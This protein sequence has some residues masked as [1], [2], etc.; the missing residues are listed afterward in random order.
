MVRFSHIENSW[1]AWVGF[2]WANIGSAYAS[3]L[4]KRGY[5]IEETESVES[6]SVP[7]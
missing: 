3:S 1:Q 5:T 2:G 4:V 7:A 6:V